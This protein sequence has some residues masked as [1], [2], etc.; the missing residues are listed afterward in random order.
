V[1]DALAHLLVVYVVLV[2][3]WLSR[4]KY[5]QLQEKVAAGIPDV[6]SRFYKM[7]VAQQAARTA[8]VLAIWQSASIPRRALGLVA[9]ASWQTAAQ[10][11]SIL[12]LALVVS[13]VLFRYW[14]DWQLRRALKMVGALIPSSASE[15]RWFAAISVGAGIS[16]ELLFRGFLLFYLSV[17]TPSLSSTQRIVL[18]S[19]LFGFCHLYQGWF[20]VL[21][22]SALGF[23]FAL[24]YVGS[25]SLLV[26]VVVHAAVD[27][28]MLLILTPK[29]LQALE[30]KNPAP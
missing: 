14:G 12:L 11:L 8:T 30:K 13:V 15:R 26:P 18:S 4:F 9:P 24:L 23:G 6:R 19:L 22:T 3:P 29:R 21:G 2:A 7:A 5:R 28:R 10:T 20:G 1:A 27:L 16:E 17:Y 25:G